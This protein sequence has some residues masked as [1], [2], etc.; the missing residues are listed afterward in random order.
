MYNKKKKIT[1]VLL[2]ISLLFLI[3]TSINS[4]SSHN[5]KK[6]LKETILSVEI[7]NE[8][9]AIEI[10][11]TEDLSLDLLTKPYTN[12]IEDYNLEK[13]FIHITKEEQLINTIT[14]ENIVKTGYDAKIINE[15]AHIYIYLNQDFLRKNQTEKETIKNIE[16]TILESLYYLEQKLSIP[17]GIPITPNYFTEIKEKAILLRIEKDN[18]EILDIEYK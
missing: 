1:L 3:Y 8:N 18:N 15:N 2:I 14:S 7:I 12:L 9:P 16:W 17:Q 11:K 6:T 10:K 13:L 5:D 4:F